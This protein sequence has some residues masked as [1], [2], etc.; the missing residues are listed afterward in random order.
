MVKGCVVRAEK[1][2]KP[3]LKYKIRKST[4]Q[5]RKEQRG[6]MSQRRLRV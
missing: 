1:N 4:Q 2:F 3:L 6:N 5:R